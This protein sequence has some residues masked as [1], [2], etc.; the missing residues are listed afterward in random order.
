MAERI[1][2]NLGYATLFQAVS[3]S[4]TELILPPGGAA[5][6]LTRWSPGKVMYLTLVDPN[7]NVEIVKVTNITG[8]VLTVERGQDGTG[9]RAWTA[10]TIVCQRAIAAD[11]SMFMQKGAFRTYAGDPNGVLE[12]LYPGEKVYNTSFPSWWINI[13]GTT[14]S[15]LTGKCVSEWEPYFDNT[16][17]NVLANGFWNGSA[18]EELGPGMALVPAD[19]GAGPWYINFM[20]QWIRVTCTGDPIT[21]Q[22]YDQSEPAKIIASN[23]AYHSGEQQFIDWSLTD[24]T[25]I[26]RLDLYMS[27]LVTN[28]EF[29]L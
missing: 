29:R 20:P 15:C 7:R 17:W 28:I 11:F 12:G 2:N 5:V 16:Y 27:T 18:W 10:G 19:N 6:F 14:W 26:G 4:D 9:A 21:L 25:G 1:Y 24:S 22:V 13:S 23:N 8:D 3:A